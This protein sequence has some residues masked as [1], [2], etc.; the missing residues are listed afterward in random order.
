MA[1]KTRMQKKV[2]LSKSPIE[3]AHLTR[4]APAVGREFEYLE[5]AGLCVPHET[6]SVRA[7]NAHLSVA[8]DPGASPGKPN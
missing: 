3:R 4:I 1:Q 6:E 5:N 7:T 8:V 2:R